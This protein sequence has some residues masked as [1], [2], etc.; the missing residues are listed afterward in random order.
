M[1]EKR[2]N[3]PR[4]AIWLLRHAC[5]DDNES[6]TGDL[7]ERFSEGQTR[8][9]FWRQVLVAFAVGALGKI[10]EHWPH[11]CYAIAGTLI[12]VFL[13]EVMQVARAITYR[14]LLPWPLSKL[15]SDLTPNA[16][17]TLAALQVLAVALVLSG[18]FRWASILRTWV[19]SIALFAMNLYLVVLPIDLMVGPFNIPPLL[20][21]SQY[22]LILLA[23]AWLGCPALRHATP[24]DRVCHN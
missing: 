12:A 14:W 15:V 22:L 6:L 10:R 2:S 24:T 4:T 1:R 21:A 9:W 20:F 19:I 5:P 8:G 3:P 16:L 11:F 23:S 17:I 13:G 18:V 7:I